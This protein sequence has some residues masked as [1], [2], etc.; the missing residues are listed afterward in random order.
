MKLVLVWY[1]R[2]DAEPARGLR[3]SPIYKYVN[4]TIAT[5]HDNASPGVWWTVIRPFSYIALAFP[6]YCSGR[7]KVDLPWKLDTFHIHFPIILSLFPT[8][9]LCI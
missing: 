3:P 4:K 1:G 2:L 9:N 5:M 7:E 8:P 6:S